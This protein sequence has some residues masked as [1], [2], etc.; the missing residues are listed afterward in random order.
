M[1]DE[2]TDGDWLDVWKSKIG[3]LF[4]YRWLRGMDAIANNAIAKRLFGDY[5]AASL[6]DLPFGGSD[7]TMQEIALYLVKEGV[8]PG[9]IHLHAEN[10]VVVEIGSRTFK[11]S[12]NPGCIFETL[13][14]VDSTEEFP[15]VLSPKYTARMM[16]FAARY[17][18]EINEM[19]QD[20][21]LK[22]MA[23]QRVRDLNFVSASAKISK[24]LAE[25]G[26]KNFNLGTQQRRVKVEVQ[27]SKRKYVRFFI[28]YRKLDDGI[29]K[30][31]PTL[32]TLVQIEKKHGGNLSIYTLGKGGRF[33]V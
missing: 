15:L 33:Y 24:V 18:D 27:I 4:G 31:L 22:K 10:D 23:A 2:R 26:F 7:S 20:A 5:N 29:G 28:P 32:Q 19:V 13:I 21:F 6:L 12:K 30:M 16:I 1:A 14:K 9:K 17:M 25:G 11:V 3:N 8:D